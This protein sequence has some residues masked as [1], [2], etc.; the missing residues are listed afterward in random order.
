VKKKIKKWARKSLFPLLGA[1]AAVIALTQIDF[2]K[3]LSNDSLSL[4]AQNQNDEKSNPMDTPVDAFKSNPM[5]T[6]E[7]NEESMAGA[8]KS[9]GAALQL[10]QTGF[11]FS[12]SDK[13]V[14]IQTTNL[15]LAEAPEN[16]MPIYLVQNFTQQGLNFKVPNHS[17]QGSFVR[18]QRNGLGKNAVKVVQMRHTK[19]AELATSSLEGLSF[20]MSGG[21]EA[22]E[23]A[24]QEIE[25]KIGLQKFELVQENP[26]A[27]HY[28]SSNG[29]NLIA[30]WTPSI[31]GPQS[32]TTS[33]Q[34][35]ESSGY[36]AVTLMTDDVH[37]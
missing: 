32:E 25:K 10:P 35:S 24:F 17:L 34:R 18:S 29:Y 2:F 20:A 11:P 3:R 5:K 4:N 23:F 16:L 13:Q 7:I 1:A 6:N 14:F 33:R 19:D 26:A 27:R 22:L 37:L 31:E 15:M 28:S 36:I 21:K 9:D 8:Q 12:E 30:L